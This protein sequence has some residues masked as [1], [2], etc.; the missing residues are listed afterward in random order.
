MVGNAA[1]SGEV[2]SKP[3]GCGWTNADAWI[4]LTKY[5]GHAHL[6][7][8]VVFNINFRPAVDHSRLRASMGVYCP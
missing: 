2:V 4:Y 3:I 5:F 8:P 6:N 7:A 1:A